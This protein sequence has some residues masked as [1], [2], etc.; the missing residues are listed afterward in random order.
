MTT[1]FSNLPEFNARVDAWAA[2]HA[3][4]L[5]L[6]VIQRKLVLDA[7][8]GVVNYTP[9]DTGY[10]R[11]NWQVSATSPEESV[12]GVEG[13]ELPAYQPE[14]VPSMN[15]IDEVSSETAHLPRFGIVW[16][17]NNVNYASHLNDGTARIEA[18]QMVER[19]LTDLLAELA[20]PEVLP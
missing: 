12:R 8:T 6:G 18:H 13:E 10:C 16:V 15:H 7:M 20:T 9:V 19:T 14:E 1:A 4:G 17:V 2:R 11:F 3:T 5:S